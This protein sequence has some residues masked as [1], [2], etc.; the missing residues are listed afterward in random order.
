MGRAYPGERQG[1]HPAPPPCPQVF[2]RQGVVGRGQA[3]RRLPVCQR[4]HR[5]L[6]RGG[7]G[8]ALRHEAAHPRV[9]SLAVQT[10]RYAPERVQR[11]ALAPEDQM[12]DHPGRSQYGHAP[13]GEPLGS[14]DSPRCGQLQHQVHASLQRHL[15]PGVLGEDGEIPPLD[16][17][18]AHTGDYRRIRPQ[19]AA[20]LLQLPCVSPVEGIIFRYHACDSHSPPPLPPGQKFLEKLPKKQLPDRHKWSTIWDSIYSSLLPPE[21]QETG[22]K[23]KIT[24]Q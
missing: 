24:K 11:P 9:V 13:L 16:K 18:A 19:A 1:K 20:D 7:K 6:P 3:L 21:K 8:H 2:H 22:W 14:G 12:G 10:V 5:A 4:L 23:Q 17:I 15:R